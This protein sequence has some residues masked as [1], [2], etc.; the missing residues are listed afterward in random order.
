M[1]NNID[2]LQINSWLIDQLPYEV[3]CK[4]SNSHIKYANAKF[5]KAV[6][7]NKRNAKSFQLL[8]KVGKI[9]GRKF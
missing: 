5:C 7:Y 9:A 4:G 1:E 8:L 3:V 6:G 2:D